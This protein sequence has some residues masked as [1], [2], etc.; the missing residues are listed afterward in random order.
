M[1]ESYIGIDI[2]GSFMKGVSIELDTDSLSVTD[3]PRLVERAIVVKRPSLLGPATS[4]QQFQET[5]NQLIVTLAPG[6]KLGGIGISTAGIVDYAGKQVTLASPH[7]CPLAD[8]SWIEHLKKRLHTPV[9]LIND[10]DAAHDQEHQLCHIFS[11]E[12]HRPVRTTYINHLAG[13]IH[14]VNI[15]YHTDEILLGGG[16]AEAVTQINYP[17]AEEISRQID[18]IKLFPNHE[19]KVKVMPEGNTLPLIGSVLLAVGEAHA[20]SNRRF[21]IYDHCQTDRSIQCVNTGGRHRLTSFLRSDN[22]TAHRFRVDC[23]LYPYESR[24][25]NQESNQ[26]FI[27]F[28]DDTIG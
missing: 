14:L 8:S 24:N 19:I 16:L 22:T 3:I 25:C 26:F 9:V 1:T 13:I 6:K 15:L 23:R 10:A 2:G 11:K 28:C 18:K 4:V 27:Y 17:L 12:E 21:R 20:Q 7:L 5:L